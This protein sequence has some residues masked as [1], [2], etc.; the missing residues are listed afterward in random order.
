MIA[1]ASL[2]TNNEK[3]KKK[4]H[5]FIIFIS[6]HHLILDHFRIRSF[7]LMKNFF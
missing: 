7:F 5:L 6:D 4:Y 3:K 2:K 1:S